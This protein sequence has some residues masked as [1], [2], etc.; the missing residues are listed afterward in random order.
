[1]GMPIGP[2][3]TDFNPCCLPPPP[4]HNIFWFLYCHYSVEGDGDRRRGEEKGR[5][6]VFL[7]RGCWMTNGEDEGEE[8]PRYRLRLLQNSASSAERHSSSY[9]P[10]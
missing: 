8:Q 9:R 4:S 6:L 2:G 3:S 7:G 10:Q 5:R 1:M